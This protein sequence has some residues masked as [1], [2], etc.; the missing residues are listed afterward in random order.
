MSKGGRAGNIRVVLIVIL[1]LLIVGLGAGVYIVFSDSNFG[2]QSAATQG[3]QETPPE[4]PVVIP[5]GITVAGVSMGGMTAQEAAAALEEKESELLSEIRISFTVA[6][7][8]YDYAGKDIGVQLDTGACIEEA[9]KGGTL[10]VEPIF[11]LDPDFAGNVLI[12]DSVRMNVKPVDAKVEFTYKEKEKFKY[13]PEISGLNVKIDDLVTLIENQVKTGTYSVIEAPVDPVPAAV[14]VADLKTATT[15]IVSFTS[16]YKRSSE[17]GKNRVHN[18]AKMAG[19]LNGLIVKPGETF[20]VNKK[21]G[22]RTVKSGWKEAAGIVDGRYEQQAGGG[23]C[24]VSGTLYNAVLRAE[25]EVV[26]RTH[27]SWPSTYLPEGLDATISWPGPDFQFRNPYD[28]PVYLLFE[29]NT[30]AKSLTITIYGKPLAHGYTVD[31]KHEK[32]KTIKQPA[33]KVIIDDETPEGTKIPVNGKVEYKHGHTG[34]VWKVYKVYKDKNGK[35]VKTMFHHQ[36]TY[37]AFGKVTYWNKPKDP[38]PAAQTSVP[39]AE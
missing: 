9:L 4:A 11:R 14:T 8:Q 21:V 7:K 27:H 33:H 17:S 16:Y 18:I 23:V 36:D 30:K 20:S 12:I 6:G 37:K 19:I 24:Q 35:V 26:K 34:S 39:P 31:F 5:A 29:A 13:T 25:L 2:S 3:T 32:I 28:S 10:T 38:K 1:C 22:Q 15:K